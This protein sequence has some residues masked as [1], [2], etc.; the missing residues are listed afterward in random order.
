[1]KQD[2]TLEQ[3]RLAFNLLWDEGFFYFY[4]VEDVSEYAMNNLTFLFGHSPPSQP[5]SSLVSVVK[6]SRM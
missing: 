1:M 2:K 5:F 4:A 6:L 3:L